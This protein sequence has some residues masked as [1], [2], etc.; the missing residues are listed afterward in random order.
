MALPVP[1]NTT[2]DV[3]H[4][5]GAPPTPPDVSGVV[6]HLEADFRRRNETGEGDGVTWR[7][8]HVML[9]PLEA[10]IR[11]SYD[12]GSGGTTD[13]VYVP[14]QSGTPF[15]VRFVERRNRGTAADHKRVYLDRKI[16][17]WPTSE[18]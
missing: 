2:C 18:I 14:D 4:G 1:P 13:W 6:C 17:L 15:V 11:D 16:A 5:G 8:T 10:D 3:Y 7:F 9:V 12:S